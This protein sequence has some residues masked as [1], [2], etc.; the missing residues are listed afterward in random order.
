MLQMDASIKGLRACLLQEEKPVYFASKALTDAQKGYVAIELESHAVAWAMEIFHHFL[1]AS[2]FILETDQKPLE[3]IL[4]EFEPSNSKITVDTDQDFCLPL[5]VRYIPGVTNQLAD[6]L[7][8]LSCQKD[9]FNLPKLHIHQITS[10]PNA[11]SDSLNDIRI[12]TQGDDEFALLKHNIIH[13]WPST[14]REV[15]SEIRQYW[16]FREELT[17]EDGIVLKGTHIVIS[18]RNI[19][20]PF[21]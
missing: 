4:S 21:N 12:A 3:T 14:I 7:S 1:Y 20:L 2:Y 16:T 10:Q 15:P 8:R 17:V 19:K 11:R 13:G 9:T 18:T 5:S 6:C